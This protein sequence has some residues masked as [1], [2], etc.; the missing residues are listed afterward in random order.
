[1]VGWTDT[2]KRV[3]STEKISIQGPVK[4]TLIQLLMTVKVPAEKT[5]QLTIADFELM[6]GGDL[7]TDLCK[8]FSNLH[9]LIIK[10]S[11][12]GA[13]VNF[14]ACEKLQV[15]EFHGK[16]EETDPL[17]ALKSLIKQ[18]DR[19]VELRIIDDVTVLP[20]IAPRLNEIITIFPN[21]NKLT[22]SI[23]MDDI[24]NQW[25]KV[26]AALKIVNSF[27]L[28][29]LQFWSTR[30]RAIWTKETAEKLCPRKWKKEGD[31]PTVALV[32][33]QRDVQKKS[34]RSIFSK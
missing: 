27:A 21:L 34:S 2:L 3:K 4:R 10:H 24:E 6:D 12:F 33:D 11:T 25:D 28:D 5:T 16:I 8:H 14:L 17:P 29:T 31:N 19:I 7:F 23:R 1:M 20:I 15:V 22:T 13:N 18:P 30:L 26:D 9:T 32:C